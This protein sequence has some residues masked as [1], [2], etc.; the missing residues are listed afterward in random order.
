MLLIFLEFE[1]SV[2]VAFVGVVL[3]GLGGADAVV[4]LD[5]GGHHEELMDN[6]FVL[7]SYGAFQT[8][9]NLLLEYCPGG[10]L[11]KKIVR[12]KSLP[13]NIVKIYAAEITIALESIH[14]K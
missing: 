4:F 8:K 3:A 7:K 9:E 14:K 10:D 13:A 6:P 12:E 2:L 5:G 1:F 11:E